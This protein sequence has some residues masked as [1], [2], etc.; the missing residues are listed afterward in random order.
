MLG[1]T[2][3][4]AFQT[5]IAAESRRITRQP[6]YAHIYR[7]F[8]RVAASTSCLVRLRSTLWQQSWKY[9]VLSCGSIRKYLQRA[10]FKS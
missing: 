5:I 7:Q 1:F 6:T 9:N 3:Y 4:V 8:R 2:V 10:S